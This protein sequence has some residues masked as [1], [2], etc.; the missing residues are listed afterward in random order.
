MLVPITFLENIFAI[1][2]WA[3][4]SVPPAKPLKKRQTII[5]AP[6]STNVVR[7]VA[8]DAISRAAAMT[9]LAPY[10]SVKEPPTT[11]MNMLPSTL[12]V[13]AVARSDSVMA[14]VSRIVVWSGA[15]DVQIHMPT[16]IVV[17]AT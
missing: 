9:L 8:A 13:E 7:Q 11:L 2:A 10:L 16:N 17:V 1:Q 15:T 5:A 4:I 6:V 14:E 3:M 12:M